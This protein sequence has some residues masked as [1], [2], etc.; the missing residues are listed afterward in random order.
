MRFFDKNESDIIPRHGKIWTMEKLVPRIEKVLTTKNIPIP[1]TLKLLKLDS[2]KKK[3]NTIALAMHCFWTGE[4]HLGAIDGVVTTEAGFYDKKEVTLVTYHTD[5]IDLK[6]L[7]QKAA[8]VKCANKIYLKTDQEIKL[9]KSFTK[10]KTAQLIIKDYR[11]AKIADQ[12]KQLADTPFAGLKLT[13]SQATKVN[14]FARSAPKKAQNF[15]TQKQLQ[16]IQP[17]QPKTTKPE[18]IN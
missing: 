5:T 4:M 14:A 16:L 13:P 8:K 10:L 1:E 3:H 6:T 15:L 17:S 7:I 18:A 12:K 11:P 2:Q 9:A